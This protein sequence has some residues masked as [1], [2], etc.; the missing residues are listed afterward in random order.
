[1]KK[2]G[3]NKEKKR[4]LYLILGKSRNEEEDF[5]GRSFGVVS[6]DLEGC[7]MMEDRPVYSE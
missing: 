5:H 7:G 6:G 4:I 3:R 1:M 2:K